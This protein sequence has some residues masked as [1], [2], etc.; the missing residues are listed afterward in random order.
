MFR[1]ELR[2]AME[3]VAKE[4]F[5]RDIVEDFL[6][7]I[8][9]KTSF[10]AYRGG[11]YLVKPQSV[12]YSRLTADKFV[13]ITIDGKP[14][15]EPLKKNR[16]TTSP[17]WLS[18]NWWA[19]Q[20]AYLADKA[21][22]AVIHGHAEEIVEVT[23]QVNK[24]LPRRYCDDNGYLLKSIPL[25]TEESC[26]RLNPNLEAGAPLSIPVVE[27]IDPER[28]ALETT[29]L[30]PLVNF[31]AIRRHGFITVGRDIE[32]ALGITL[33][34]LKEI[35][36]FRD[37]TLRDHGKPTLRSELETHASLKMMPPHFRWR[38]YNKKPQ[39]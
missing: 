23:S 2:R 25:V 20:S 5:Q 30:I 21:I 29:R 15:G 16:I 37:I 38:S 13:E 31:F 26:W 33:V 36:V 32:E 24:K 17:G 14:L 4:L 22:G 9:A 1:S 8:S 12:D 7:T 35:R 18:L 3:S 39:N 19:H 10:G 34:I 6:G 27:D 11:T 28:L